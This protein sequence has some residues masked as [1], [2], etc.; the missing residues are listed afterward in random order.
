MKVF[1]IKAEGDENEA[2]TEM[3]GQVLSFIF[4]S[5]GYYFMRVA[6]RTSGKEQSDK[7]EEALRWPKTSTAIHTQQQQHRHH[8]M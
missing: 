4:S 7:R 8:S 3:T 5:G 2:A 6:T 1:E